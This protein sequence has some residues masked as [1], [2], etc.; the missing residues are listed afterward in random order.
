MSENTIITTKKKNT[1]RTK[2]VQRTI[3]KWLIFDHGKIGN[4]DRKFFVQRLEKKKMKLSQIM[5]R[6]DINTELNSVGI[7]INFELFLDVLI[8]EKFDF[9]KLNN[10]MSTKLCKI[11]V[12]F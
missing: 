1:C 6:G 8:C 3:K 7:L 9:F 12:G 5:N 10:K 11:R 2:S 4:F